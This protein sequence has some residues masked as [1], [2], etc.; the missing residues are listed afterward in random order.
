MFIKLTNYYGGA[1]VCINVMHI[2]RL[3]D[4][5]TDKAAKGLESYDWTNVHLSNGQSVKV[6]ET[7]EEILK[8]LDKKIV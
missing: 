5:R 8:I 6:K 1:D 2:V 7:Q 4:V 3:E